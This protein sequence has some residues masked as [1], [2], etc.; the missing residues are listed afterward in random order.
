M[1]K[2]QLTDIIIRNLKPSQGKQYEVFEE[3]TPGFGLRISPNG[4]KSF[5]LLYRVG[6]KLRRLTPR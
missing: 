4:T 5:V 3:Q 6:K 1:K 2:E